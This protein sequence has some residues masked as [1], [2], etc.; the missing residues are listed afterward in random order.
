MSARG[1]DQL[2]SFLAHMVET[3]QVGYGHEATGLGDDW[4]RTVDELM[5]QTYSQFFNYAA[6]FSGPRQRGHSAFAMAISG[7]YDPSIFNFNSDGPPPSGG[8]PDEL[9]DDE[10]PNGISLLR[11][12]IGTNDFP[13]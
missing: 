4:S 11:I 10:R 7:P 3:G 6:G 1:G 9:S 12:A 2:G 13:E 5:T 8:R